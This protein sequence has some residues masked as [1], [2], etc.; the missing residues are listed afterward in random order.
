MKNVIIFSLLSSFQI[1][2]ASAEDISIMSEETD[3]F[4]YHQIAEC[5]YRKGMGMLYYVSLDSGSEW[6][7]T[8]LCFSKKQG[9]LWGAE[10]VSN[11]ELTQKNNELTV[12]ENLGKEFENHSPRPTMKIYRMS[13][14]NS[15]CTDYMDRPNSVE[16]VAKS[17]ERKIG[18]TFILSDGYFYDDKYQIVD[19]AIY[20][21]AH[22]AFNLGKIDNAAPHLIKGNNFLGDAFSGELIVNGTTGTMNLSGSS[23]GN[24]SKNQHGTI[25]VKLLPGGRLTAGGN[26]H[27][28]NSRTKGHGAN[29]WTVADAEF[30][31]LTGHV[32]GPN[33]QNLKMRGGIKG[34]FVDINNQQHS[35]DGAVTFEACRSQ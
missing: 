26:I 24:V 12:Y 13:D 3:G 25:D 23:Q 4:I 15:I 6:M 5:P 19:D 33:G 21:I 27:F 18:S 35:F 29:E 31:G 11:L 10:I 17:S 22:I 30:I 8:D 34:T 7:K 16:I 2:P 14:V 1:S 28:E 20:D 32:V 9:V